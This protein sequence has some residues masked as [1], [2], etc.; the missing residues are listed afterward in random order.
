[1]N[2]TDISQLNPSLCTK[3]GKMSEKYVT[4]DSEKLVN[5]ILSLTSKGQPVFELRAIQFHNPR[6]GNEARKY[7][8]HIVRIQ[9]VKSYAVGKKD[10]VHPEMIIRNSYDGS[11]TFQ[12]R[13]GVFRLVCSNGLVIATEDFGEI[14]LRHMGTPEEAAFDLVKQFAANL[15]KFQEIQQAL[16]ERQLTDD[17]KVE[18]AMKAAAIRFNKEFTEA[19]AEKLLEIARPEDDGND[20]W[21]VFNRIQE[22]LMGKG[23]KGENM[24]KAAKPITRATEDIRVNAELFKL[25]MSY[26][27][28][29][30]EGNPTSEHGEFE[31]IR[32]VEPFEPEV[33]EQPDLETV[34]IPEMPKKVIQVRGKF[35]RNPEYNAWVELYGDLV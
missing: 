4:M 19:D 22:K 20:M 17:E 7:G 9:T 12:I 27:Q 28:N 8:G 31:E 26:I 16:I 5:A 25:A 29:D 32:D 3:F 6:K 21:K 30:P 18:F 15:P 1:M 34:T 2:T 11:S 13:M 24:K 35:Q 23:F 10:D 33:L 14:K